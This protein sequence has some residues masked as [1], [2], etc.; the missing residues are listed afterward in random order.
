MGFFKLRRKCGVSQQLR[1]GTQVSSCVAPGQSSVHSSFE[2]E[3]GM[4]HGMGIGP[5]DKLKKESRCL[6]RVAAGDPV[7]PQLVLN[8]RA[9]GVKEGGWRE[10]SI[11]EEGRETVESKTRQTSFSFLYSSPFL[12][13]TILVNHSGYLS[14]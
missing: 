5:Q 6:S 2:G 14:L 9:I 11:N 13:T 12:P 4:S 10:K 8:L 7:F 3:L 1:W